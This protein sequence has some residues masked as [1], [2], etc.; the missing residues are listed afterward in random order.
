MRPIASLAYRLA[1]FSSLG[2]L[3]AGCST[4][5]AS[6]V[7]IAPN[8]T[9]SAARGNVVADRR[10]SEGLLR[11]PARAANTRAGWISPDKRR[12][13]KSALIYWGSYF[14]NTIDIFSAKGTNPPMK[15]QITSGLSNPERLFVDKT[16][17]V[18]ATNLGN[19][20]ITAYKRGATTP[21][22]TIS[23]GVNTP[24]G[25]T[26]DAAGTV[27]CANFGNNTV[28][29]YPKGQT[30]PSHTISMSSSP[31]YLA[32]DSSDN[33]YVSTGIGVTEFA[34]GS[35]TGK[36]LGLTIGSPGALEVDKAGNII[37][38]DSSAN[39]IDVF[40]AGQTAPSKQIAV[41]AGAPFA[42][43]LNKAE[44]DVY[45]SVE[46]SGG[47]IVQEVAYPNGT[48]MVNKIT[49]ITDGDWPIA[50]SADA[51]L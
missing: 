48:T 10:A 47:F 37:V 32:I 34:P 46:V 44:T 25:L 45:A 16:M 21:F 33:L 23:N 9:Q 22:L 6:S 49:T 38:I 27:Y 42:L 1:V 35:G 15:G 3:A 12:H 20:T 39:T 28:T 31:E 14:N 13:R 40:P 5:G 11:P 30:S 8:T 43:S 29:V 51:V 50:V 19:N 26:V 18:Y 17:S 41:T 24:T 4:T 2:M 7:A 36:N